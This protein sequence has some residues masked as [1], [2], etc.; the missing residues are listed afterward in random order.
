MS[1]D[2]WRYII[3]KAEYYAELRGEPAPIWLAEEFHSQEEMAEVVDILTEG[4]LF[5]VTGRGLPLS[6]AGLQ[7][8]LD[9]V[10]RFGDS[11]RVLTHLENHDEPR[12]SDGTGWDVWT[13]A[14]VWTLGAATRSTP[15]LLVGQEWGEPG[16]LEFRRPHVLSGRFDGR[17]G[18]DEA[19]LVTEYYRDH[20]ALRRLL[21]PLRTDGHRNLH[22]P[23]GV[24]VVE[25]ALAT[26]RWSADGEVVLSLNNLWQTDI[27]GEWAIP[28]DLRAGLGIEPCERIQFRD[29]RTG[30]IVVP[31]T[32]AAAL[33]RG[34]RVWL[35]A[36]DRARWAEM[37]RCP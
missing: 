35:S 21:E 29:A 10:Y 17:A 22:P 19:Q 24:G 28:G 11:A 27:L 26:L 34:F 16:R 20:I 7:A 32:D 37:E 23:S 30:S 9:S 18:S 12:L 8:T 4:Y 2:E 14:G 31:C 36:N 1:A 3:E 13:G 25:G 5:G 6:A 33:E 15:M